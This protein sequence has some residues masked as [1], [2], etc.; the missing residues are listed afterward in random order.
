MQR[1]F[2]GRTVTAAAAALAILILAGCASRGP[3][4]VGPPTVEVTQLESTLLTPDILK[5]EAKIVIN[6]RTRDSMEFD[7]V[8][9]AVD[10][11]DTQLFTSS[12]SDLLRTKSGGEQTVTFPFQVAMEDIMDSAPELLA[13]ERVRVSFR[14]RV[15]PD[16][17]SGY[18]SMPFAGTTELPIPRIPAVSFA[19]TEGLP[20]S[21]GFRIRL[22]V[23]NPNPFAIA[24]T[25]V[26]SYMD[27]NDQRYTL[28][29][30][31]EESVIEANG[32][33]TVVLQMENTTGTALSMI[34][35]TVQARQARINVGGSVTGRSPYGWVYIPVEVSG[36]TQ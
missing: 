25:Q 34:L 19:G 11:F 10:L 13:E 17:S 32:A 29:H 7:R 6:N 4:V 23:Q 12:F 26:D 9:Y 14:G 3:E 36:R 15:F 35:N 31:T 1:C 27:L 22:R 8:D 28:V 20:S 24:V 2:H 5:F 21:D 33:G 18:G 30:S 16:T